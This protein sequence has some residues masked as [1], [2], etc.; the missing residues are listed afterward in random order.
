MLDRPASR[1]AQ[2]SSLGD[3]TR[4]ARAHRQRTC[5]PSGNRHRSP[6]FRTGDPDSRC[7]GAHAEFSARARRPL[8]APLPSAPRARRNYRGGWWLRSI[9][10]GIGWVVASQL[11]H[12]AEQLPAYRVNLHAK[13]ATLQTPSLGPMGRAIRGVREGRPG[14]HNTSRISTVVDRNSNGTT[15][16]YGTRPKPGPPRRS[17]SGCR[18]SGS[19]RSDSR[20]RGGIE[21]RHPGTAQ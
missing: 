12:I 3:A 21:S 5:S 9:I 14:V 11:V 16:R 1:P 7:P 18:H 6:V 10:G 20:D 13:L 2:G 17:D 4:P 8:S 19:D 15:D